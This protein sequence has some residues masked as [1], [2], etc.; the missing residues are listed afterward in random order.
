MRNIAF[1]F[2]F[3]A[4]LASSPIAKATDVGVDEAGTP[5][6]H[7]ELSASW[8][9]P[10][11]KTEV[12]Y[13]LDGEIRLTVD[14]YLTGYGL[15]NSVTHAPCKIQGEF[16]KQTWVDIGCENYSIWMGTSWWGYEG[17]WISNP[18]MESSKYISIKDIK[19]KP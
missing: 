13:H 14:Y 15:Q 18:D 8:N 17:L 5:W 9:T 12:G 16:K 11:R 19:P 7:D 2:F 1:A 3:L 6:Q 4:G 10:A